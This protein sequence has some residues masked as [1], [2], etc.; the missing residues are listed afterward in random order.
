MTA[1]QRLQQER[2]AANLANH[3][4]RLA[5]LSGDRPTW[6]CGTP[7]DAHTRHALLAQSRAFVTSATGVQAEGR[8]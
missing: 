8:T 3:R 6:S 2:E 1:A 7:V 5:W 4:E